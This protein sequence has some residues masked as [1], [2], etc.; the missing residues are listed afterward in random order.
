LSEETGSGYQP[1]AISYQ[2]GTVER[3]ASSPVVAFVVSESSIK[4]RSDGRN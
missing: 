4:S 1:P 2:G 3:R